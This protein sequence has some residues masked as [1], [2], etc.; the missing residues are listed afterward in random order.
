MATEIS[1]IGISIG[2]HIL[3]IRTIRFKSKEQDFKK[4]ITATA[5]TTH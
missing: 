5:P 3:S 2:K 4:M 1:E